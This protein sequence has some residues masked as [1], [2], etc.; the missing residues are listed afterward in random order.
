MWDMVVFNKGIVV[1]THTPTPT[2]GR[3]T[4]ASNNGGCIRGIG[5]ELHSQIRGGCISPDGFC[6]RGLQRTR[7]GGKKGKKGN[8]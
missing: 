6:A 4:T 3:A 8:S 7:G 5:F 2:L 1:H